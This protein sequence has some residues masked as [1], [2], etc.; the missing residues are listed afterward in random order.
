MVSHLVL[1]VLLIVHGLYGVFQGTAVL[2]SLHSGVVWTT[3][4]HNGTNNARTPPCH[5]SQFCK[6]FHPVYVRTDNQTA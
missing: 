6:S 3:G 1:R 2:S 5:H 4:R